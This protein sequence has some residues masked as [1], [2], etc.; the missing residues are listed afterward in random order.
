MDYF[1]AFL[2]LTD[3]KCVIVGGGEVAHRKTK[4]LIR[5]GA[6]AYIVSIK[7]SEKFKDFPEDSCF[8]IKDEFDSKHLNGR[9]SGI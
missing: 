2:D 4:A 1:P 7:F 3:K 6:S 5:S 9:G 8:L